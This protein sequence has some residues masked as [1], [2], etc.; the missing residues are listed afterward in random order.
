[1]EKITAIKPQE[2][3]TQEKSLKTVLVIKNE[4]VDRRHKR[5]VQ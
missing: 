5:I 1:M 4:L 3:K 2:L